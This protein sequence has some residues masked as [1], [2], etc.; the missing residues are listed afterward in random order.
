MAVQP[1]AILLFCVL[2]FPSLLVTTLTP[3]RFNVTC[4]E[5][6]VIVAAGSALQFINKHHKHGFK[7]KLQEV[8][9]SKYQQFSGACH[10]DVN[11]K[12]VQTRCHISNPKPH[13][14][15]ELWRREERGALATCSVEFWVIWNKSKIT[16]LDCTTRPERT[17]DEMQLICP[18]CPKLL[19]L[20]DPV[21][22]SAVEQAVISFNQ[23]SKHSRY[24]GL[25]EVARLTSRKLVSIGAVTWLK[26]A[27][28]E[29]TCPR[30]ASNTLVAC[31]PLCP[32]R[33]H[34]VFCQTAYYNAHNQ[35]GELDCEMY[36]PKDS[37][38]LPLGER[39]PV[40]GPLFHDSA[41]DC[42]CKAKLKTTDP[43]IHHI[44][45]FPLQ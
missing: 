28:V 22:V 36:P 24:F 10:I 21:G 33:A 12:L 27:L 41:E 7:F 6:S 2:A 45:P 1:F 9:S 31:T 20:D 19:P 13:Q 23:K 37:A 30:E 11:L 25:M 17:N 18:S 32:D 29:T 44:C 39:E 34:N 14:E 3:S 4:S 8:Q 15:C 26:F 43:A 35:V 5:D 16:K 38:P 40:C 42:I